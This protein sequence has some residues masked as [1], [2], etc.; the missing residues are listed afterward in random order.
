MSKSVIGSWSDP[1]VVKFIMT[2]GATL[3]YIPIHFQNSVL[4]SYSGDLRLSLQQNSP[5]Q[6]R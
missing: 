3:L 2:F 5:L 6:W 1:V 4:S